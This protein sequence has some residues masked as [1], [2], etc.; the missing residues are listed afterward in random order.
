M[1]QSILDKLATLVIKLKDPC[2]LGRPDNECQWN[3]DD[4]W[5]C[6]LGNLGG[7]TGQLQS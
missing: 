7:G 3:V 2:A 5:L 1:S 4:C 6:I